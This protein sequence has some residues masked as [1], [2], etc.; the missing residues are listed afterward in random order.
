MNFKIHLLLLVISSIKLASCSYENV[1]LVSNGYEG[2]VVAINPNVEEDA[3]IIESLK[4][5]YYIFLRLYYLFFTCKFHFDFIK[6]YIFK[7]CTVT[8]KTTN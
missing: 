3:N 1:K 8:I 4:V 2:V 5:I 6:C 7:T